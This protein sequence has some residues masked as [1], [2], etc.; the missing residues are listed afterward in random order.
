MPKFK[1]ARII[2]EGDKEPKHDARENTGTLAENTIAWQNEAAMS[3]RELADK[4]KRGERIR[5]Q[6]HLALEQSPRHRVLIEQGKNK[7]AKQ[8][9]PYGVSSQGS[10]RITTVEKTRQE[11]RTNA[12]K[13]S[14]EIT[15]PART[16][17]TAEDFREKARILRKSGGRDTNKN[18]SR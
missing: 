7:I 4:K 12:T 11:R 17:R 18:R 8:T 1:P 6:G 9:E 16:D 15:P 2:R 14:K 5:L 10:G 3:P 13:K